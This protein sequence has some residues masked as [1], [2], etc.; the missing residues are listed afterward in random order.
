VLGGF[1]LL[2]ISRSQR[3]RRNFSNG[4]CAVADCIQASANESHSKVAHGQMVRG[5]GWD[6]PIKKN[7]VAFTQRSKV[8]YGLWKI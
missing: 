6:R 4:V 3:R 5:F 8:S 1:R 2:V 7:A